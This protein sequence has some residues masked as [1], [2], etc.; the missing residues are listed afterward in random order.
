M[1]TIWIVHFA[2][3]SFFFSRIAALAWLSKCV[4]VC[5]VGYRCII[6]HSTINQRSKSSLIFFLFSG[7]F[8]SP[9]VSVGG[10]TSGLQA[11]ETAGVNQSWCIEYTLASLSGRF[12]K[13]ITLSLYPF[14]TYLYR[15]PTTYSYAHI[16]VGNTRPLLNVDNLFKRVRG[17]NFFSYLT[18]SC[19]NPFFSSIYQFFTTK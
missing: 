19:R 5:F 8:L 9:Q 6:N 3:W 14:L 16:A 17:V 4:C 12:I 11:T 18:N 7:L 10:V 15:V 1:R 2:P 13:S